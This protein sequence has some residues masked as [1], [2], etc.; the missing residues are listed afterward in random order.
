[1]TFVNFYLELDN[2]IACENVILLYNLQNLSA[3]L[4]ITQLL[5]KKK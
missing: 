2:L 1:M 4:I 3:E 5:V